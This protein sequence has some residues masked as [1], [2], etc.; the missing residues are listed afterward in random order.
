MVKFEIPSF[1]PC[2]RSARRCTACNG[3]RV[4]MMPAAD[5]R[6]QTAVAWAADLHCLG[7]LVHSHGVHLPFVLEVH[8]QIVIIGAHRTTTTHR[9][10]P[11]QSLPT[12][13]EPRVSTF[14]SHRKHVTQMRARRFRHV[15]RA[16]NF[17]ILDSLSADGTTGGQPEPDTAGK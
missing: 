9:R 3:R 5:C 17:D 11:C 8:F 4:N 12:A 2:S 1:I 15:C 7:V 6:L 14:G 13:E 16:L 10:Q